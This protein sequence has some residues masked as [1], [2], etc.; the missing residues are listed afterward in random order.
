LQIT[1]LRF[2][3]GSPVHGH[4]ENR[5]DPL[6]P[7]A[8]YHPGNMEPKLSVSNFQNDHFVFNQRI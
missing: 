1:G 6:L 4:T 8:D 5:C 3:G 7:T 2:F